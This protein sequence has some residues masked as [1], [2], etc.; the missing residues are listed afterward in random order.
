MTC[1]LRP[2]ERWHLDAIKLQ[3]HQEG[4][5]ESFQDPDYL[6]SMERDGA[7]TLLDDRQ[8]LIVFGVERIS[9]KRGLLWSFPAA[10]CIRFAPR[11]V[12]TLRAFI[13]RSGYSALH[14]LAASDI[15]EDGRAL[16]LLGFT[17]DRPG[18]VYD[19]Y[20]KEV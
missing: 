13:R 11:I 7:M 20:S 14:A 18:E 8:P 5:R 6:A 19:L 12:L 2:F 10:D 4:F 1:T 3:A 9:H 16:R 17:K 15:K